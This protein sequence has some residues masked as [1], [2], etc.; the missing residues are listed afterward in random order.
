MD[1]ADDDPSLDQRPDRPA[2]HPVDHGPQQHV[3]VVPSEQ[4]PE[5]RQLVGWVSWFSR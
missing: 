1:S 2:P 5:G 4:E 3:W